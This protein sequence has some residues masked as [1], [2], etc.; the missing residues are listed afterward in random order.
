MLG[1]SP[2]PINLVQAGLDQVQADPGRRPGRTSTSRT[3]NNP[4]FSSDGSNKLAQTAPQPQ[5]C[6]KKG[7]TQCA[8]GTGGV[9]DQ[10]T[11]ASGGRRIRRVWR[12]I[13]RRSGRSEGA[14]AGADGG[15]VES[16]GGSSGPVT[17]AGSPTVLPASPTGAPGWIGAIA[18]ARGRGRS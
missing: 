10:P 5:A 3:C 1:Y 4:T 2:L 18:A 12:R 14:D 16:L 7:P 9:K 6:D 13:D 17:V 15:E 8:T 11:Q